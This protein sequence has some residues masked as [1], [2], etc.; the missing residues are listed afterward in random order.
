MQTFHMEFNFVHLEWPKKEQE[1]E[2]IEGLQARWNIF[3][4]EITHFHT[5]LAN[6]NESFE[7]KFPTNI[8]SI[9]AKKFAQALSSS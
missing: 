5:F 3:G 4:M 9:T 2:T 1:E 6:I 8:F 7:I